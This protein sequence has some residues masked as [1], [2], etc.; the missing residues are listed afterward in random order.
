MIDKVKSLQNSEIEETQG[1]RQWLD[2]TLSCGDDY[3]PY[4]W[5]DLDPLTLGKPVRN[6]IIGD[7]P[8]CFYVLVDD[9]EFR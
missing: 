4:E 7:Y 8:C 2:A 9:R 5:G 6:F 1:D 3:E